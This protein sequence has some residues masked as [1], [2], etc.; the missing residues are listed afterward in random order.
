M[1]KAPGLQGIDVRDL[2]RRA[3]IDDKYSLS[4]KASA[5]S[6]QDFPTLGAN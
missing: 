4:G 5:N 6:R 3:N 1:D 2:Y